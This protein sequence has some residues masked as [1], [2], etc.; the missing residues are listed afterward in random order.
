MHAGDS[1]VRRISSQAARN[2]AFVNIAARH[3]GDLGIHW[4]SAKRLYEFER[5][6]LAWPLA[7]HEFQQDGVRCPHVIE[8]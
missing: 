6:W 7:L 2:E 1:E 8:G 3:S 5:F 4:K